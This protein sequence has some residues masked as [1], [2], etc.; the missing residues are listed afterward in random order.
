V[1]FVRITGNTIPAQRDLAGPQSPVVTG[2]TK[3]DFRIT[4]DKRLSPGKIA[5]LPAQLPYFRRL[6][7]S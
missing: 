1:G 2:L 7:K 5:N 6:L 3:D 4:E